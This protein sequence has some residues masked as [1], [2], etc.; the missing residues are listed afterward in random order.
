MFTDNEKYINDATRTNK[1]F[2]I[3]ITFLQYLRVFIGYIPL[4]WKVDIFY[5]YCIEI[6]QIFRESSY[7][8]HFSTRKISLFQVE[9][10]NTS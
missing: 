1:I 6:F 3:W 5:E 7:L 10:Y 9:L 8:M 2:Q 4:H